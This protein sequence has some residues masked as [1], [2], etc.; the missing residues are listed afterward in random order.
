MHPAVRKP[1]RQ[2]RQ[3][4]G[5]RLSGD[6]HSLQL[7]RTRRHGSL[8]NWKIVILAGLA[9]SVALVWVLVEQRWVGTLCATLAGVLGLFVL[10][11]ES[12]ADRART[13]A[14]I[15][16]VAESD[17]WL[18]LLDQL[19]SLNLSV[20]L[21]DLPEAQEAAAEACIDGFRRVVPMLN[22]EYEGKE[23]TRVVGRIGVDF[24]APRIRTL[25]RSAPEIRAR[26]E[27]ATLQWLDALR[28]ELAALEGLHSSGM[29]GEFVDK[30]SSL[31]KTFLEDLD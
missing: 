4:G 21:A 22:G 24:F 25:L 30:A 20:R 10:A 13:A 27:Q 2:G 19:V 28:G 6:I 9:L 3:G 5:R 26:R 1:G 14:R 16:R 18:D 31:R 12:R 15:A 8:S 11:H 29:G 17:H 7:A 23:I